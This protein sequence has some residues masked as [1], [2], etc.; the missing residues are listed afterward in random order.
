MHRQKLFNFDATW[1]LDTISIRPL[2]RIH[3]KKLSYRLGYNQSDRADLAQ[4]LYCRVWR[5]LPSYRPEKGHLHAFVAATIKNFAADLLRHQRAEK[6]NPRR[7]T[8][9][10]VLVRDDLGQYVDR[11]NSVA[12]SDAR[13]HRS[14]FPRGGE[15]VAA[16]AADVTALLSTLPDDLRHLAEQLK[17]QNPTQI[18]RDWGI[19]RTS[20]YAD[21]RKLRAHFRAGG[22]SKPPKKKRSRLAAVA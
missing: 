2:V 14:S 12:E 7:V 6:R 21:I 11:S 1:P 20:L 16:E 18:A 13:R 17:V 19:P 5:A 9:L 4:S 22:Y 10:N 3:A 15:E 8:S